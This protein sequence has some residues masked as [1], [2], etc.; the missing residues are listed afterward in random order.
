[1][2]SPAELSLPAWWAYLSDLVPDD[3]HWEWEDQAVLLVD[4][5]LAKSVVIESSELQSNA[6]VTDEDLKKYPELVRLAVIAEIK[7]WLDNDALRRQLRSKAVNILTSRYVFTWKRMSDGSRILKCR[8]TVHGFKDM[9][10]NTVDRY[11]GTSSRW[12]KRTVLASAVQSGWPV[13]SMDVSMAFLKGLTFDQIQEIKGGPKR[14]VSMRLPF[15]KAGKEPS[16]SVLLRTFPGYE[17]F[18]DS[19]EVLEMLKGGFGV[20]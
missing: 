18:N 1:M 10:K 20:S 5:K 4:R 15:G 17:D 8:I 6:N 7:R 11:S 19:L 13:A 14:L 12:G 3:V 2:E 9:E 16:G